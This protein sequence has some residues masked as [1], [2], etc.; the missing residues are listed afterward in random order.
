VNSSR[1]GRRI[2][3]PARWWGIASLV[4][5][6]AGLLLGTATSLSAQSPPTPHWV[7]FQVRND[8]AYL[9]RKSPSEVMRYDLANAQWLPSLALE[10]I[11][12]AF[13]VGPSHIYV[14]SDRKIERVDLQGANKVH[15]GNS[16][17]T[18]IALFLDGNVLIANR[19]S[20]LYS[21]FSSYSTVTHALIDTHEDYPHA[22]FGAAHAPV[23]NRIYG[24]TYGISPADIDYLAYDDAGTFLVQRDSPYHGVYPWASRVWAWPDGSKVVDDSGTVYLGVDL[25]YAGTLPA[26]TTDVAFHGIDVPI[27]LID[28]EVVAFNHALLETGRATLTLPGRNLTVRGNTVFVFNEDPSSP[29]RVGVE[30]LSLSSLSPVAPGTPVSPVGLAYTVTSSAIDDAGIIYVLSKPHSSIFRWDV[31]TQKYLSTIPL[32][33][34]GDAIV[35]SAAHDALF[36]LGTNRTI[37]RIDLGPPTPS[38]SPFVSVP[39][40]AN[41]MLPL[42]AD[43]LVVGQGSWDAQWVYSAQ[44]TLLNSHFMCCYVKFHLYDQPRSRLFVDTTH[45]TYFGNGQ[46]SER[47]WGGYIG[48]YA[49]LGL[50]PDGQRILSANGVLYQASPLQAIDYLS[51]NVLAAQW[52]SP[53]RLLTI[54]APGFGAAERSV[55]QRW[56]PYL[57]IEREVSLLGQHVALFKADNWLVELTTSDGVPRF[58][59]LDFSLDLVPPATLDAPALELER[60]TALAVGLQWLDVQGETSYE[61]ERRPAGV[62]AWTRVGTASQDSNSFLDVDHHSGQ[63][64][65]YRVRARN[66]SLVSAWSNVVDADLSGVVPPVPV[67]PDT[68]AFAFDDAILGRDD[69]IYILSREHRSIFVWNAR[70][71]RFE[72]SIGLQD[73]PRYLTYSDTRDTFFT[74]YEDGSVFSIDPRAAVPFEY[75]FATLGESQCG[76]VAAG[77]VLV[78][79][80]LGDFTR[81]T[82][83]FDLLGRRIDYRGWGYPIAGGVWSAARQRVYH[84]RDGWTPNDLHYLPISSTG[85]IGPQVDSPYHTSTGIEYPIRVSPNGAYVVLGSGYVFDAGNLNHVGSLSTPMIDGAW[86]GGELVTLRTDGLYWQPTALSAAEPVASIDGTGKRIFATSVAKLVVAVERD[87]RT[88]LELLDADFQLIEAPVFS[89]GFD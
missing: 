20:Y 51:N 68:V 38:V 26:G 10:D 59:V 54:R 67:D 5:C 63:H 47:P 13:A 46:F 80:D 33:Q 65:E 8:I 42:G 24:R 81:V 75:P 48:D 36:L 32:A 58:H 71:Q 21:R 3:R 41:R 56:S 34:T 37:Y 18:V 49:P 78:A 9:L 2:S 11:P 1:A 69:R 72:P 15:V 30:Q 77:D 53:T 28:A 17:D 64:R 12:S 6:V 84:F 50:S 76:L 74:A 40:H 19:S 25:T 45:V 60:A 44:G 35:F 27:A 7:E 87:G 29:T 89:D 66:G 62:G 16:P 39:A 55:L 88:V 70:R 73:E 14:A 57:T 22:M 43:L 31:V 85:I 86:L 82:H 61:V 83:T 23:T 4:F 79:C 52:A